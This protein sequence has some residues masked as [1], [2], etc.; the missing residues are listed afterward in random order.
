MLT[1]PAVGLTAEEEEEEAVKK[2]HSVAGGGGHGAAERT[3]GPRNFHT[4]GRL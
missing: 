4:S 1:Q 2:S 3:H